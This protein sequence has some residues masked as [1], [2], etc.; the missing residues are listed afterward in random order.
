MDKVD[1]QISKLRHFTRYCGLS[2]VDLI[3]E[4]KRQIYENQ[5]DT[6]YT[7]DEEASEDGVA[8]P[9]S[10]SRPTSAQQMERIKKSIND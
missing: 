3:F 4:L 6:T 2:F 8:D 5:M 7:D 9:A 1:V 10:R